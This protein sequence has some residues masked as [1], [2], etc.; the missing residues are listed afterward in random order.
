V[1]A[2]YAH[3]VLLIAKPYHNSRS[4]NRDGQDLDEKLLI[5]PRARKKAGS[6]KTRPAQR[7]IKDLGEKILKSSI[8]Q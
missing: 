7:A 4:G 6:C 8:G 3:G 1:F 2:S 5:A